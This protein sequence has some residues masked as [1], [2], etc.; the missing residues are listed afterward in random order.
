MRGEVKQP[1]SPLLEEAEESLC[2]R[3]AGAD[4]SEPV[5][6]MG[7][8]CNQVTLF[9]GEGELSRDKCEL[10]NGNLVGRRARP[11]QPAGELEAFGQELVIQRII[12]VTIIGLDHFPGNPRLVRNDEE[13]PDH[14]SET[15]IGQAH[16]II[17]KP[18]P[19]ISPETGQMTLHLPPKH[20]STV[21]LSTFAELLNL[22]KQAA[23]KL[24]R[25]SC[26]DRPIDCLVDERDYPSG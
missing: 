4:I 16:R 5:S 3:R 21:E 9:R 11:P 6:R 7:Q 26:Q 1:H 18:I 13:R 14:V 8:T 19:E 12:V 10:L 17:E 25:A 15:A 20:E 22:L 24:L 23:V 2:A